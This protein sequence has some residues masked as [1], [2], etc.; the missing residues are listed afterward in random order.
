ML[1]L[2]HKY[3]FDSFTF[4]LLLIKGANKLA[5]FNHNEH[6][7]GDGAYVHPHV[8]NGLHVLSL[9]DHDDNRIGYAIHERVSREHVLHGNVFC[10]HGDQHRGWLY[11]VRG[12]YGVPKLCHDAKSFLCHPLSNVPKFCGHGVIHGGALY[13]PLLNIAIILINYLWINQPTHD[14]SNVLHDRPFRKVHG[15]DGH[16]GGAFHGVH[17]RVCRND[18]YSNLFIFLEFSRE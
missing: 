2:I 14:A 1:L 16:D 10:D 15:Y 11:G 7:D 4:L 9:C 6:D 17:D 5:K 3:I 18:L 8:H 13:V 12:E